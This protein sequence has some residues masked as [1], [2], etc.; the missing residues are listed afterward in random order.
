MQYNVAHI[1][2]LYLYSLYHYFALHIVMQYR[3]ALTVTH[4]RVANIA[5]LYRSAQHDTL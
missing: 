2:A 1:A 5:A 3:V 4:Y